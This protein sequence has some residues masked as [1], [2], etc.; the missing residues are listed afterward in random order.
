MKQM[1]FTRVGSK[2]HIKK[3]KRNQRRL[4]RPWAGEELSFTA[5][6]TFGGESQGWTR[7]TLRNCLFDAQKYVL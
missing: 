2:Y 5:G 1:R 7:L 4:C 3:N 6:K